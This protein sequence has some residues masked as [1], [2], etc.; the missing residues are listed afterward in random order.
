MD[1][2]RQAIYDALAADG[3][4]TGYLA[5][6]RSDFA[7]VDGYE[8]P[9]DME[10]PAILYEVI[11]DTNFDSKTGRVRVIVVDFTIV[12]GTSDDPVTVA[13][14]VR[15][16]FHRVSITVSGWTNIITEVNGPVQ[17][18]Q[19]DS[20]KTANLSIEFTLA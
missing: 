15:T 10:T 12:T 19:D 11:A 3:T 13:E 16:L 18:V 9:M 14:R 4:L 5:A 17:G 7:I 1:A 2:L 20:T 8:I 6:Y